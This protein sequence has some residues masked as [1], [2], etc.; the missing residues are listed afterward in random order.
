MTQP[1][2]PSPRLDSK[3]AEAKFAGLIVETTVEDDAPA[4]PPV[5][6][7]EPVAPSDP[8][9]PPSEPDSPE[10]K[11]YA[12]TVDGETLELDEEEL[13]AGY[14]MAAH[15]T[16]TAQALGDEK[17][18]FEAEAQV[19]RQKEA[20]Y[21]QGLTQ[22]RQALEKITGEPNW[23]ERRKVLPPDEFLKEKADWEA[24]KA[25]VDALKR[26]EAEIQ[27]QAQKTQAE[28]FQ[29]YRRAEQDKLLAA[30]PEWSDGEKAKTEHAKLITVAKQYGYTE[31]D[32]LSVTDHRA[33]LVLR[34]AMK[35]R[36]LHR[37]PNAQTKAK[38]APIKTARPGT[39]E[40]PRPNEAQQ[41]L[42]DRAAKTGHQK[43]AMAAILGAL[44]DT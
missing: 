5:A 10:D 2:T 18:A 7:V 16:R 36:E 35:Y 43:D 31:Q 29:Q 30:I 22:L 44:G 12:V 1:G 39:P 17:R 32:M 33:I 15:N 13:K 20:E 21:A 38:V 19:V 34:D 9:P 14:R 25:E 27:A 37:E 11:R 26:H 23:A 28:Q 6:L 40:R 24:S 42:I 8:A 4:P 3:S 41:K